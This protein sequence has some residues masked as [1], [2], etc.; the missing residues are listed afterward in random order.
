MTN[1][2]FSLIISLAATPTAVGTATP[3]GVV[4]DHVAAATGQYIGSPSLA[5]LTNG[6][7]VASHDYFGPRSTEH[8][9]AL[10]AVF[11][12]TNRGDNWSKISEVHGQF[13]STLF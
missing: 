12:S 10:S 13:W 6:V 7:Y 9:R 1:L 8:S 5:I 4:I 2:H 11:Q 3:P